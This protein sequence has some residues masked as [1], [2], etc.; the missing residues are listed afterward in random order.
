MIG[1][2][3]MMLK[4]IVAE[5]GPFEAMRR[6]SDVGFTVTEVSQIPMTA[7]NVAELAR[8][9]EEFGLTFAALSAGLAPMAGGG[10]TL[11]SD[12]DKIVADA[13][14]LGS[15]MLRV[16]MLPL[17]ALTDR[18]QLI[19]AS[20][21]LEDHAKRLRDEG[22]ALCYHN[23]HVEFATFDG[24]YLHDIIAE[25]APSVGFELDVHWVQRAGLDPVRAIA[26]RAGRVGLVHLKDY[27]IKNLDPAVLAEI[28]AGGF[29]AFRNAVVTDAAVGEGNLDWGRIIPAALDA[30][31]R[32]LLV[33]QEET[34]GMDILECLR[35][36]YRNLAAMG[37]GDLL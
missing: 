36:S 13:R 6:L 33:E 3:A 20:R 23:H 21:E 32:Y 25:H 27:R 28:T 14:A 5:V 10:D 18:E 15:G 2:Q 9:R 22:I 17:D 37:F 1:V 4:Q 30:G 8:A 29:A 31:A 24:A 19:D 16:A 35:I 7:E 11:G 34:E 26:D 12:F